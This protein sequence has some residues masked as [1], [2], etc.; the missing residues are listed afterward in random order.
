MSEQRISELEKE[1]EQMKNEVTY[2][3]ELYLEEKNRK[4]ILE[5]KLKQVKG[6]AHKGI[7]GAKD[8]FSVTKNV[9]GKAK[10]SLKD[11]WD[12]QKM[13]NENIEYETTDLGNISIS[14][15][16]LKEEKNEL[17]RTKQFETLKNLEDISP[18]LPYLIKEDPV[19]LSVIV[20]HMNPNQ[21]STLIDSLDKEKAVDVA[22]SLASVDNIN[23][24]VIKKIE[25]YIEKKINQ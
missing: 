23:S 7:N 19:T 8:I 9:F 6:V 20:S 3:K 12:K 13:N 18:L 25:K 16:A 15:N 21:A 5:E 24:E 14:K 2:Y 4:D 11:E 22:K 17:D 1:I 10:V